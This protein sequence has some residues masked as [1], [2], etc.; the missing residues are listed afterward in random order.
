MNINE[1]LNEYDKEYWDFKGVKK[2]GLHTLGRY[3]A[4][5]VAPMQNELLSILIRQN[6]NIKTLL[7]PF[8]GSATTLVEGCNLGLDVTGIDINP[9]AVLLGE[10]K[11]CMYDL[12]RINTMLNNVEEKLFSESY[13]YSIHTFNNIDKWFKTD[14]INSLSKIRQ[15]I[16]EEKDIW[17]KKF[18][19]ICFSEV[20]YRHSNTRTN[21]FKL[22]LKTMT[23]IESIEDNC[24]E[25]FIKLIKSNMEVLNTSFQPNAKIYSGDSINVLKGL[26]KCF[27]VICTSPPY[28]DNATTVTYGQASILYLKWIDFTDLDC[29]KELLSNYS[30]IDSV[31]LGGRLNKNELPNIPEAHN[32][33]NSLSENKQDKVKRFIS[34]YYV[35]LKELCNVLNNGGYMVFTVGNRKVDGIQQPLDKITEY[36][37]RNLSL[38][39]INTFTRTIPTKRIPFRVSN[40]KNNG[41]VKSI[42]KETIII[43]KK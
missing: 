21:T 9:Y 38:K 7:D 8:M 3:P 42:N 19:W 22:H 23:D 37:F 40:V 24:F 1:V 13:H 12:E 10:V 41:S 14:I 30:R 4:T 16:I 28:G 25:M 2:E 17:I 27:D 11:T 26:N 31:S 18:L 5:M 20:I 43:Y 39:K 6:E 32:Y 15:V 35:V 36:T 29:D 34:D 33:I